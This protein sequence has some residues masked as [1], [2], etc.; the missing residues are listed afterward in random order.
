MRQHYPTPQVPLAKLS[1]GSSG[2]Q[3]PSEGSEAYW[4]PSSAPG[5]TSVSFFLSPRPAPCQKRSFKPLKWMHLPA[6]FQ[7][8]VLSWGYGPA[9]VFSAL[10][11]FFSTELD[12][13][14]YDTTWL[15]HTSYP[16]HDIIS[17]LLDHYLSMLLTVTLCICRVSTVTTS[18]LWT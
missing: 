2:I 17:V 8:L 6:V 4:S 5:K 1:S 18:V 13:V 16:D 3:S 12:L 7:I 14:R 15:G 11:V 9:S 10:A